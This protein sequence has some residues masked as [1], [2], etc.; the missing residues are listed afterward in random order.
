MIGAQLSTLLAFMRARRRQAKLKT[1]EQLIAFQAKRVRRFL[2]SH[3]PKV[4]AYSAD[5]FAQLEQAP[6]VDKATM[7]ERF[8]TYNR[9]GLT[10]K[11][12]WEIFDG[13]TPPPR[14]FSIGASTGTSGNR[15]LYVVSDH[16]RYMW[17]GVMLSRAF[18]NLLTRS[19]R[20]AV[21][22]PQAS[23]LYDAA[24]ESRR[25]SL[26]FF[27]L[28]RGI[29]A[30]FGAIA[31][32][33]PTVLVAPPRVLIALAQADIKLVPRQVFS[34]AEVLTLEDR[35]QIERRFN[36]SV[37][38]IYMATEG[39][40][41]IAC[42]HGQ[43][44]LIEDH[45]AFEWLPVPGSPNLVTPLVTDFTR[46]TQIMLRYRMN[47]LIEL[48]D[49]V[50]KCGSPHQI[51]KSVVGRMDDAFEFR[52]ATGAPVTLTPDVIRNTVLNADRSLSDYRV[53]QTNAGRVKLLLPIGEDQKRSD[54]QDALSH[55]FA[56][57]GIA[58]EIDVSTQDL[59][60]DGPQKRRRVYVDLEQAAR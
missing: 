35:R 6:I 10:A 44:H 43:L 7:M 28:D 23:R 54:I 41:A 30:Q 37:R 36:L 53:I 4:D 27:D 16:E 5:H 11:K 46:R 9:L 29:E 52:T 15:G 26:K 48:S 58:A 13:K 40:F 56:K 12:G 51:I 22:L 18:P 32:F 24:N 60:A 34:G 45:L 59:R 2:N 47:D 21:I 33:D 31:D 25:L 17:L 57:A 38:Q 39:L 1:R 8:E 42:E 50:C 49:E 14:G 55:L 19:E 3:V 20:V